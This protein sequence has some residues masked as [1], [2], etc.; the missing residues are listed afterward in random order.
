VWRCSQGC[1]DV[2]TKAKYSENRAFSRQNGRTDGFSRL[3]FQ[4]VTREIRYL[5]DQWNFAAYQR[6][7]AASSTEKQSNSCEP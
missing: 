6:I 7:Q 5:A 1:V 2:P 4:S 3:L